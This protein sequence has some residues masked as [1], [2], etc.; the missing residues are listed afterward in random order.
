MYIC[1]NVFLEFDHYRSIT[2]VTSGVVIASCVQR[3]ITSRTEA[4]RVKMAAEEEAVSLQEELDVA[5]QMLSH[6][7][8]ECSRTKKLLSTRVRQVSSTVEE[9]VQTVTYDQIHVGRTLHPCINSP[10]T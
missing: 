10:D 3:E 8:A 6:C 5:R 4:L 9:N 2:L 7:Q 1:R